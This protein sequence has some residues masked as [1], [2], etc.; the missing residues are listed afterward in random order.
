[1]AP[2]TCLPLSLSSF[3]TALSIP[4]SFKHR[5]IFKFYN[6]IPPTQTSHSNLFSP[7]NIHTS[8]KC[9][10][11]NS[12]NLPPKTK[13]SAYKS[14]GNLHS[15]PTYPYLITVSIC[16]LK[17]QEDMIQPCLTLF[18]LE[19]LIL[20]PFYPYIG[21][22]INIFIYQ[23]KTYS[24]QSRVG[25]HQHQGKREKIYEQE[26]DRSTE[27]ENPQPHPGQMMCSQGMKNN[28]NKRKKWSGIPT[29]L[30][31]Y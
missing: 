15:L 13:S 31:N 12:S 20:L 16:T 5:E 25:A 11:I 27:G 28:K 18:H 14:P 2:A 30:P 8:T 7:F 19:A 4:D 3:N 10:I 29:Q 17:T 6:L 24:H 1:M 9:P 23:V 21:Q 26:R 22:T